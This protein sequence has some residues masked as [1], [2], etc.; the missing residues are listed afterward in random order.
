[1]TEIGGVRIAPH[2]IAVANPAFDVTPAEYIAAIVTDTGIL[3]FPYNEAIRA[4]P[5]R[6]PALMH[7]SAD[8]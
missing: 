6:E 1:V 5:D 2:G 4:L 8:Y 7:L 3:R